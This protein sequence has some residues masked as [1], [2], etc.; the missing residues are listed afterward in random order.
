MGIRLQADIMANE[1]FIIARTDALSAK[2]IESNIDPIDH[3]YIL[4][5]TTGLNEPMTYPEAGLL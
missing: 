4:G 3:P 5:M 2:H 1:L